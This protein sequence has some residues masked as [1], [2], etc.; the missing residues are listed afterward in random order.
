MPRFA[1]LTL[2]LAA[3]VISL[4]IV[5]GCTGGQVT[6]QTT[7]SVPTSP[8]T[9]SAITVPVTTVPAATAATTGQPP[10][11]VTPAWTPG[12]VLQSGS[13]ILITG[14]VYGLK[15]TTGNYI[16]EIRFTAVKNPR[17]DPVTFEI[18]NT[19]II[20]SKNGVPPFGV[21]YH[22]LSGDENGD[23]ILGNGETFMVQVFIQPPNE[24]YAGETFTMAIQNPPNQQVI[25]DAEAP[26]VLSDQPMV[27]A[28]TS[29]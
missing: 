4:V 5:S 26:P 22:I 20:F 25:V 18:P 9:S 3:A 28:R 2:I 1:F 15:S 10:P 24:I 23:Q 13:A 17:A 21:N 16:D 29:S 19:Q 11:V 14:N 12:T 8:A 7:P 6:P 27:L